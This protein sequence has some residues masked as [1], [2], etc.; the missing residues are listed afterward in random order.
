MHG[1]GNILAHLVIV[2][3]KLSYQQVSLLRFILLYYGDFLMR[4]HWYWCVLPICVHMRVRVHV[5]RVG[6]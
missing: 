3:Y 5:R 2:G 4:M 6:A 1:E